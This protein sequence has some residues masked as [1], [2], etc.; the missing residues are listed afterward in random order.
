MFKGD[1]GDIIRQAQ[2]LGEDLKARQ[3]EL[4]KRTVDVSVGG[5]MVKMTFN[6]KGEAISITIDPEVVDRD[7]VP[8]LQ[9][10]VLSAVNEGVRR[11]QAMMQEEMGKVTGG[12]NIPGVT[13]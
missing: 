12:L 3:E 11:A 9:D 7:D 5:G 6:G 13:S 1:L 4:A 8:M 2:Q 10:L